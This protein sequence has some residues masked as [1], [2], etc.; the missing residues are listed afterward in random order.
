[1]VDA[2]RHHSSKGIVAMLRR[3][4][5]GGA[6]VCFVEIFGWHLHEIDYESYPVVEVFVELQEEAH[7]LNAVPQDSCLHEEHA[8]STE[9]E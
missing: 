6:S 4:G 7:L 5:E 2:E 1:M 3:G 8:N 9:S